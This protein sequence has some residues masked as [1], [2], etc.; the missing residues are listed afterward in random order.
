MDY[1]N[2][3]RLRSPLS[4]IYRN[5]YLYPRLAKSLNGLTLDLGCGIGD[6]LLYHS[7][8]IGADIDI[9]NISFCNKLNLRA[10]HIDSNILPFAD[11]YFDSLIMDNV[12]EH[13]DDPTSILS[14]SKRVLKVFSRMIIGV[15]CLKGFQYD[16]DHKIYY[17]YRLLC[18]TL[19]FFDF[20]PINSFYM[21]LPFK[22]LGNYFKQFCLYTEFIS[23]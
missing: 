15:P 19:S 9:G 18:D 7:N 6:F 14:E 3:L 22:S 16:Q 11:S 17:D 23:L 8:C 5:Y 1:H 4:L 21:P 20:Y 13:I 10:I 2:Y 12:I